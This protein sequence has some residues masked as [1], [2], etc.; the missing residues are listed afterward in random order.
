MVRFI[1]SG[2]L[3]L[4]VS[5][6]GAAEPPAA[7][8]FAV[9]EACLE[10]S[11][12]AGPHRDGLCVE[13]IAD[14]CQALPGGETTRRM[15]MCLQRE[16][17]VWDSLLNCYYADMIRQLDGAAKTALREAQRAWI[18]FRDKACAFG[19]AFYEGG[20][21]G[22]PLRAQCLMEETARRASGLKVWLEEMDR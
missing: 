10:K 2:A 4:A 1:A 5:T 3:F 6:A 11:Q 18:P 12:A 17:A 8:D 15:V 20:S 19:P 13:L 14:P 22:G 16:L 21:I 9:I 7:A